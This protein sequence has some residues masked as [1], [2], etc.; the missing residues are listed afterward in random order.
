MRLSYHGEKSEGGK[1]GKALKLLGKV[2]KKKFNKGKGGHGHEG[3]GHREHHKEENSEE[4]KE[5][6]NGGSGGVVFGKSASFTIA[7]VGRE[8]K[9]WPRKPGS[10]ASA[11]FPWIT[12]YVLLP[13]TWV[14]RPRI[15]DQMTRCEG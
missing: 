7:L 10:N 15:E 11:E 9:Q 6:E 5:E 8:W 4:E 3:H 13:R 14:R 2:V 1:T 12:P